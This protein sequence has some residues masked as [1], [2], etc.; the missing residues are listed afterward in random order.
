MMILILQRQIN[1]ER[2]FVGC[3]ILNMIYMNMN[4][5][6]ELKNLVADKVVLYYSVDII[7]Y[8]MEVMWVFI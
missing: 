4:L 1:H 7:L 2:Y 5:K 6:E 8:E 3:V